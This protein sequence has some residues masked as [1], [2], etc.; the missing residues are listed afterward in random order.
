MITYLKRPRASADAEP[1]IELH[2]LHGNGTF[3]VN[4]D[5]VETVEACPD[6]VVLMVNKHRYIVQDSV[7]DVIER[8]IEF[9]ARIAAA[10]GATGDH[11]AGA[12]SLAVLDEDASTRERAA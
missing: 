10:A 5:L 3:L 1:V 4:P 11:S 8:I 7:E 12:R 6:T 2:R 9:R